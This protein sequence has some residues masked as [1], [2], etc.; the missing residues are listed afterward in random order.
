MPI[1]EN[2]YPEPKYFSKPPRRPPE[3]DCVLTCPH[4]FR[5]S[6]VCARSYPLVDATPK[7]TPQAST[8]ITM[9]ASWSSLLRR[10]LIGMSF[11]L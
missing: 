10:S 5:G 2:L 7:L 8:R 3:G 9:P 1:N 6:L 4:L 11:G